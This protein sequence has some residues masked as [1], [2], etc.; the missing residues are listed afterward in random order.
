MCKKIFFVAFVCVFGLISCEEKEYN[1]RQILFKQLEETP[2]FHALS[3]RL[4]SLKEEGIEAK[5]SVSF[6][7][8]NIDTTVEKNLM[9]AVIYENLGFAETIQFVIKYDSIANKIISITK[10]LE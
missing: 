1:T 2:E 10:D 9:T 7:K 8:E 4:D 5:L 6:L 3:K